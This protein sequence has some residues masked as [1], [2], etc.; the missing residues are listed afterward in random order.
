MAA[1]TIVSKNIGGVKYIE[2]S[3]PSVATLTTLSDVALAIERYTGRLFEVKV[4]SASPNYTFSLFN[5][6]GLSH[7]NINEIYR[8]ENINLY[9]FDTEP[10]ASFDTVDNL[11]YSTIINH[12]SLIATGVI[13]ITLTY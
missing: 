2:Y 1:T 4:L 5:S 3:I 12:D 9:N 11:L 10:K 8:I 7:P 13:T 6:I